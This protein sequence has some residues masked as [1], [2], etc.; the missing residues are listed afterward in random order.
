MTPVAIVGHMWVNSS[1]SV[2]LRVHPVLSPVLSPVLYP[3]RVCVVG[4]VGGGGDHQADQ[5]AWRDEAAARQ[6]WTTHGRGR[7]TLYAD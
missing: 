6:V 7:A 1:D 2:S 3:A 5:G 4:P